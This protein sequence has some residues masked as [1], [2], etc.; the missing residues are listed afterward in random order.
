MIVYLYIILCCFY[1][2]IE[3]IREAFYY[4][5]LKGVKSQNLHGVYWIQ[6][7]IFSVFLYVCTNGFVLTF[8]ICAFSFFHNGSYF[9]MRNKLDRLIYPKKFFDYS[10]TSTAIMEFNFSER[11]ILLIIGLFSLT[12]N[13]IFYK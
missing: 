1:A 11:L 13:I 6:R 3:G 12:L 7:L 8:F 9:L 2:S 4:H 10:T 5:A